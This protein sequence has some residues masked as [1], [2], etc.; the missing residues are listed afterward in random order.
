MICFPNAKIN[1]GLQ[2]LKK[3]ADGFHEICS[4]MVPIQITDALE[5]HVADEFSFRQSGKVL[6][7]APADNII[8]KT[9]ELLKSRKNYYP[10][11]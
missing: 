11:V 6:D 5:I 9:Y 10:T 8:V 2:I 1:L 7:N 3:R 4:C